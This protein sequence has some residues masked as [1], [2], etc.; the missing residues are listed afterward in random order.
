MVKGWIIR[1]GIK[2][3]SPYFKERE[4][5]DEPKPLKNLIPHWCICEPQIRRKISKGER[6][7]FVAKGTNLIKGVIT[8]EYNASEEQARNMLGKE[9]H[10]LHKKEVCNHKG[11]QRSGNIII[12]DPNQSFWI[13]E[14]ATL[15]EFSGFL[16]PV[17]FDS[18]YQ[19]NNIPKFSKDK[20]VEKLYHALERKFRSAH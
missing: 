13:G 14:R 10:S 11:I 7:F 12:G 2:T 16:P 4:F 1:F 3:N 17:V 8:V 15:D 19:R 5:S 20:Q 18:K 9:W 6:I